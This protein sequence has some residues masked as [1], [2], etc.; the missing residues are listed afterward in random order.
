MK[1]YLAIDIGASSGRHIAYYKEK[2][3]WCSSEIHRFKN[4]IL[5]RDDHLYWDMDN[6]KKNLVLGLKKAKEQGFD[7]LSIGIDTFG[8]DYALLDEK[9]ELVRDIYC[10]QDR[11]NIESKNEV[12]KD[13]SDEKLFLESGTYPQY[14]NTLFQLRRD[15]KLGYLSKT[16]TILYFASYLYFFL[17]GKKCNELSF[18]STSGLLEKGKGDYSP[19]L[20]SYLGLEKSQFAPFIPVGEKVGTLR[21]EIVDEIGYDAPCVMTYTHDT[22]AS[23]FGAGIKK[24]ELFLSS[25]TWSLLGVMDDTYH[26]N[27]LSFKSGFT[28]ELNEKDQIRFL[29][30]IVGMKLINQ[31]KD[32]IEKDMDIIKV[33]KSAEEGKD[34]PYIFD[35]SDSL[36]LSPK[37]MRE[38]IENYLKK[39]G[40][41]L[42][43]NDS[44]FFYCI[45]HSLVV[46]YKKAIEEI[47]CL[48]SKTFDFICIFG[49]GNKNQLVNR[50][51]EELT[52]KRVRLGPSE[53]TS[54]GNVLGQIK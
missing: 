13:F 20:L 4:D 28:N 46:Q 40:Y 18:A 42:P 22:G 3:N 48:T 39:A 7:V 45:Y 24:G 37:N 11:A 12:L 53:A 10:Y 25:G 17:T 47:E 21:K 29:K 35:A 33:V 31:A 51:T 2:D 34:Y 19:L 1:S 9:D 26:A 23:C 52:G 43:I 14:F 49:G 50:M 54:F 5:C 15:Q 30:N 41:P 16:K 38:E 44:Q 32:E 6:L 27:H 8:V 36:F